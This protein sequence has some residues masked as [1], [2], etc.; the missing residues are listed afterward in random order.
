MHTFL[1]QMGVMLWASIYAIL[2]AI[3]ACLQ[4]S[5][6]WKLQFEMVHLSSCVL[7]TDFISTWKASDPVYLVSAADIVTI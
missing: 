2:S 3:S 5:D 4:Y 7:C 6:I 1:Y